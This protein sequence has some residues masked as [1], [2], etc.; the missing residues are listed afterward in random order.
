MRIL[1]TGGAEFIGSNFVHYVLSEHDDD[2][3]VTL[4]GLTYVGSRDNLDGV[5]DDPRR[6][7][8]EGDIRDREL[9][10]ELIEDIGAVVNFAAEH[11]LIAR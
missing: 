4:D 5:L 10:S 6:A 2:E 1:V 3:V 7:F 8:V 11:M 9:V